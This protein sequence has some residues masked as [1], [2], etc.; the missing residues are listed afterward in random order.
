MEY[1]RI[2]FVVVTKQTNKT[3]P[4]GVHFIS[5]N[6]EPAAPTN[7]CTNVLVEKIVI[8]AQL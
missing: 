7:A 1:K 6:G 5:E 8:P 4:A 2:L 3:K